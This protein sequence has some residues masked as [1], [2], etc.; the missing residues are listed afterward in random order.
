MFWSFRTGSKLIKNPKNT[1]LVCLGGLKIAEKKS[2]NNH[3]TRVFVFWG[4][5]SE[6]SEQS[7]TNACVELHDIRLITTLSVLVRFDL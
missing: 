6:Q 5:W 7:H 1:Q 2:L 4:A 3:I